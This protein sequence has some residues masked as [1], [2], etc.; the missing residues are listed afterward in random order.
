VKPLDDPAPNPWGGLIAA[1]VLPYLLW[2]LLK[3]KEKPMSPLEK[4]FNALV[5][6]LCQEVA[7]KDEQL[8]ALHRELRDRPTQEQ[9]RAAER[10][11]LLKGDE[12]NDLRSKL[13]AVTK[14]RDELRLKKRFPRTP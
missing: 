2:T 6:L 7:K 10:R 11:E 9:L 4:A 3:K 8:E 5:V 13:E 14:E 1:G 12:A